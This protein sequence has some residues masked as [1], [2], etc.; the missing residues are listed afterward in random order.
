MLRNPVL[1]SFASFLIVFI[2]PFINELDSS[3]DLIIFMTSSI[4]SFKIINVV[5]PDPKTF[6]WIAASIAYVAVNPNGIKTFLANGLSTFFIKGKLVF[7]YSIKSLPRNYSD[8]PFTDSQVFDNFISADGLFAK[9]LPSLETC[10]LINKNLC[11]KLVSLI[12]LSTTFDERFKITSTLFFIPDFNLLS[13]E[14]EK[15]TFK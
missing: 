1:C 11:G 15:F 14:L 3:R 5:I 4:Y 12:K 8:C 6:F 2:T 10:V 9:V 13:C 7:S